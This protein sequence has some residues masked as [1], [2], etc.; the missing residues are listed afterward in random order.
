MLQ[1]KRSRVELTAKKKKLICQYNDAHP[2]VKAAQLRRHFN[3]IWGIRIGHS[4]M[5][6]I[7]KHKQKWIHMSQSYGD[8]SR[9]RCGQQLNLE[10]SLFEWFYDMRSKEKPV[11]SDSLLRKAKQL[12]RLMKITDFYYSNGWLAGFKRRHMVIRTKINGKATLTSNM[13]PEEDQPYLPITQPK[14][15][16]NTDTVDIDMVADQIKVVENLSLEYVTHAKGSSLI[17]HEA[18]L[19]SSVDLEYTQTSKAIIDTDD[20]ETTMNTSDCSLE[21]ARLCVMKVIGFLSYHPAVKNKYLRILQSL[22]KYFDSCDGSAQKH[23]LDR[24]ILSMIKVKQE[25]GAL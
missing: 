13:Q 4:T 6:D 18:N 24:S 20:S 23:A 7:L 22:L 15:H 17:D 19:A 21:D 1:G 3:E 8:N 10:K 9:V 16:G 14:K 2:D 11:N 12:G 25:V 5:H